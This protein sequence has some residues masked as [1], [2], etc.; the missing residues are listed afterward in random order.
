MKKLLPIL[1]PV[2]GLV[3]GLVGG[4]VMKPS[5]ASHAPAE[6]DH[7]ADHGDGHADAGHGDDH[8]G[9]KSDGHG[10]GYDGDDPH[11]TSDGYKYVSFEKPFFA[12]ILRSGKSNALARIDVHLEVPPEMEEKVVLHEPKLRDAFLRAV[13]GFAEE[14]GFSRV[15]SGHG[16]DILRDEML[17]GARGILGPKVRSV[18][19]GEILTRNG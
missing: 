19:I 2:I 15:G 1:I 7:G 8:G 14:G 12:P 13:L 5:A 3:G 18:L 4:A 10:T 11:V 6:G 16:F 17:L 9:G